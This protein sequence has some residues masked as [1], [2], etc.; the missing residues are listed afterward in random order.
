[1]NTTPYTP[2][3][4]GQRPTGAP[5]MPKDNKDQTKNIIMIAAIVLLLAATG[6][7][8][9][10]Y[11]SE[12]S[13]TQ[14]QTVEMDTLNTEITDLETKI[15][16]LETDIESKNTDMA[17]KDRLLEERLKE[18]EDMRNKVA[19]AQSNNKIS[20]QKAKELQGKIDELSQMLTAYK[21]EI[22]RLKE[23]NVQLTGQVGTL[24]EESAQKSQKI[25]E[26]Q[27]AS[28]TQKAEIE[29]RDKEA[30]QL[31]TA[32]AQKEDV[33]STEKQNNV[34]K[35]EEL[36]KTK[37][38]ASVLRAADFRFFNVKRNDKEK[39]EMDKEFK[40]MWMQSVKISFTIQENLV[41]P[42]GNRETYIVYENPDGSTRTTE[43]SGK[44]KFG[45]QDMTYSTKVVFPYNRTATEV[46]VMIPKPDKDN[47]YQKGL[48]MIS[49]Y[50]DGKLIGKGTFDVK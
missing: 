21:E 35:Q 37:Q 2:P 12:R 14:E 44:F 6:F 45:N 5:Q 28:E 3:P 8:A 11:F 18:L 34:A 36:D 42:V 33:I 31:Q 46:S 25:E 1:M 49:A 29:K 13:K 30:K 41:A 40:R 19:N 4:G 47:K 10:K 16:G 38:A 7:F 48:Q 23:E 39:E 50:C 32:I 27:K 24:V 22:A 26:V 43:K 17:E 20:G 9:A 15:K